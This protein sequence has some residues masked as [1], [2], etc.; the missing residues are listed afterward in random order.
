MDVLKVNYQSSEA[1][2]QFAKS[3]RET[4]FA[5]LN[6]HPISKELVEDVYAEW[7]QFF[8]SPQKYDY[9]FKEETQDGF[10]PLETSET[11]KG[12]DVKD[13]KE[14]YHYYPWGRKP[15]MVSPKIT[16]LYH[17]LSA[18]GAT[19]LQWVESQLPAQIAE[20]L[21]EPL[22]QMIEGSQKTLLRILHYPPLSGQEEPGSIRAA[23]HEDINLL[24]ILPAATTKGL[25]VM[26]TK[27]HWHEVPCDHGSLVINAADMLQMCTQGYYRSTTHRVV[28]PERVNVS[29]L[30]MPLFLHPRPEV[31]LSSTHTAREYLRERLLE[32]G[33]VKQ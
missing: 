28:N 21:S 2:E 6:N 4:G 18:V 9:L 12:Y 20:N 33:L 5:V 16:E 15:N 1:P 14:F 11:A 31:R 23:A 7:G 3:L 17:Q 8:S 26:D 19:L 29:R 22:S 13:N 30:S 24:T 10:F 32:L 27:G 25:Q